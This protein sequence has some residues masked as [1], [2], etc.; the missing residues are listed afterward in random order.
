MKKTVVLFALI[1]ALVAGGCTP[2]L[3]QPANF[4]WAAEEILT[5]N[6]NGMVSAPRYSVEFSVKPLLA[7]EFAADTMLAK[8]TKVIRLIRDRAGFYYVTASKFKN[9]Y[10]FTQSEGALALSS[11]ISISPDKPMDDPKFNQRDTYIELLNGNGNVQ[12]SKGGILQG[13][14]K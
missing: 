8:E 13:G 9:V 7:K 2:L 5:V 14:G 1:T 6:D 4:S 11:T 10:V 12:L 3:L